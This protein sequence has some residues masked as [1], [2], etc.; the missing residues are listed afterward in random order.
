MFRICRAMIIM[1][2]TPT[3]KEMS[4]SDFRLF[5]GISERQKSASSTLMTHLNVASPV[6][7]PDV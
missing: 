5:L 6:D 3:K 2:T 1:M 4:R 7:Q